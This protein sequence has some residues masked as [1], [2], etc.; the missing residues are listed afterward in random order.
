MSS[1]DNIFLAASESLGDVAERVRGVLGLEYVEDP[2]LKDGVYLLRGR[3]QTVDGDVVVLVEPNV[4][5]EVD[6]EPDD[7]SA[8]DRYPGVA[9]IRIAGT[10]TEE[11][12]ARE[13][14][15]V[16]DQLVT[17]I[18]DVPMVLSHDMSL[19]V[20]A[21]LPGAGA[22]HFAPDTTLDAPDFDTWRPWVVG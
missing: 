12:Q 11:V 9:D 22:H 2:E 21:Y 20:A 6:P 14:R 8:I 17:G 19:I 15:A 10:K 16:F 5:G 4:Y 18:P 13:A 3:A 1:D 7:V